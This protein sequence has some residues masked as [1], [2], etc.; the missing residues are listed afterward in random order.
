MAL[1]KKTTIA[2]L[3]GGLTGLTL[4]ARLEKA[5]LD[6]YLIE[7]DE[8][9]GLAKGQNAEGIELD[10]GL[11]S[12]PLTGALSENPLVQLKE[13]LGLN[14]QIESFSEPPQLFNEK[15]FSEFVGF[16]ESENRQLLEEL[17]YYALA[18]RLLVSGG[19][20]S[21][22][23]ELLKLIPENKRVSQAHVTKFEIQEDHIIS[24][25]LNGETTLQA[26][27]FV[28]TF[29][30]SKLKELMTPGQ[31]SGKVLQRIARTSPL[32]A[33]SL[34]LATKQSYSTAKNIF[35]LREYS[36]THD[37]EFYVVGQFISNADP[38]RPTN[39]Q[40]ISTWMTLVDAENM[41]DDEHGSKVIKQIKKV[42][43]K[44]FPQLL[45]NVEFER[46]L[47]VPEAVGSFNQLTLEKNSTLPGL[48][49]F[50]ICG[51]KSQNTLQN[52]STALVTAKIVAERL[53]KSQSNKEI[54]APAV[55]EA[56]SEIAL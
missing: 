42:I 6:Y 27:K 15:S 35:F 14:F 20:T 51:G 38:I 23:Q 8:F 52:I 5:G 4:A 16:G 55:S 1:K 10:Y 12:I 40:Q 49:N 24:I 53:I 45:E 25:V 28:C 50:W 31:I 34:D 43:G 19:W 22:I 46:L 29:S 47:V 9:G 2:I 18:P 41:L 13:D 48:N 3:G 7:A 37:E 33:I 32:T 36:K 11:K 26:E 30:P 56:D 17:G 21:V 54:S 44:A 39:S